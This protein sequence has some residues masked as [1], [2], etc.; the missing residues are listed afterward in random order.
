[1]SKI[2]A[3]TIVVYL[4][5]GTQAE[6]R[7]AGSLPDLRN[8]AGTGAIRFETGDGA[9]A[10]FSAGSI[11]GYAV[12]RKPE[13]KPLRAPKSLGGAD[14]RPVLLKAGGAD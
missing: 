12:K 4:T 8:A 5:D 9:T 7:H 6:V 13:R 1:M 11:M 3:R 2:Y 10:H 14:G